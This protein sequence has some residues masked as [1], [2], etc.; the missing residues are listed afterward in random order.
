[1]L[2]NTVAATARRFHQRAIFKL[3]VV[4]LRLTLFNCP[5]ANLPQI[6]PPAD[7][8]SIICWS[9]IWVKSVTVLQQCAQ[10][11]P[12]W[13]E[14]ISCQYWLH[15]FGILMCFWVCIVVIR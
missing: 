5:G 1:M 6:L 8:V 9:V 13:F 10:L 12:F 3:S 11:R 2:H 4:N 7:N 14:V 15:G